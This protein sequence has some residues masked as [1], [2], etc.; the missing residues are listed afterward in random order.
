MTIKFASKVKLLWILFAKVPLFTYLKLIGVQVII[1]PQH[2]VVRRPRCALN[3][4][5]RAQIEIVLGRMTDRNVN[6]GTRRYVSRFS[7][8]VFLVHT[9]QPGMMAFLHGGKRD[10]GLIVG[11]ESDASLADGFKFV[12]KNAAELAF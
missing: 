4:R 6:R 9:E 10:S 8:L 1:I 3:T 2:V 5:V 11:F 7:G 12:L